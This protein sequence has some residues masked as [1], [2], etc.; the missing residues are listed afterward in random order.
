M[1]A[2]YPTS[3]PSFTNKSAGQVIGSAHINQL[4]DE[5]A[6]IGGG[7]LQ[8]TAPLNS[9]NST[10]VNLSV[11]GNSSFSGNVALGGNLSLTG[12]LVAA[13]GLS[14]TGTIAPAA[15]SSGDTIDYAP[16]GLSSCFAIRL[17]GAAGGST[18]TGMVAQSGG[19]RLLINAGAT[20]IGIKNNAG[21]AAANQ[22]ITQSASDTSLAATFGSMLLW[23]DAI[24]NR[25]RQI[26]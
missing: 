18:L 8:G 25:W 12:N 13:T 19:L 3:V 14:F 2:N 7:L 6:A 10:M 5:V 1:P 23:H 24:N 11:S 15:L 17:T 4:Q 16:T 9:S 26:G 20:T 22:I 21:S